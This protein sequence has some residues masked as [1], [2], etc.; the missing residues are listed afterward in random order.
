MW[1]KIDTEKIIITYNQQNKTHVFSVLK[2]F[3]I[4]KL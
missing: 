1:T 2:L 4:I 3:T